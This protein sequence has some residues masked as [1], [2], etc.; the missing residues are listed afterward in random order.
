LTIAIVASV[1]GG[2]LILSATGQVD[3]GVVADD[4]PLAI[5]ALTQIPLWSGYLGVPWFVARREGTGFATTFGVTMT[6]W[7]VLGGLAAGVV[8]QVILVP[9]MY[10]PAIWLTDLDPDELSSAARELT[11]K[12]TDPLGVGLLVLIVVVG[13]PFIEEVFFRGLFQGAAMRRFG[14]PI[15]VALPALVFGGVHFQLLQLPAL[16]LFGVI[17]GLLVW[18]YDRLGPAIW[19]HVGFNAIA[20][21]SLLS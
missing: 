19:A 8:T 9:V 15:G 17:A 21:V 6:G 11:D 12:A 7:D 5:I 10:L 13:A 18:R 1:V 4:V 14:A 20:V 2:L 16:V 3:D